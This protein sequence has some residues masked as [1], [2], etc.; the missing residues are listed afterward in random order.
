[1]WE[2][3][4]KRLVMDGESAE[5]CESDCRRTQESDAFQSEQI[6]IARSAKEAADQ[7][8]RS[9]RRA[10]II[11]VVAVIV[12]V[13]AIAIATIPLFVDQADPLSVAIRTFLD[14]I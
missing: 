13:I 11:A 12:A 10:N 3:P 4:P 7:A 5:C 1:M 6:A 9:A 2:N 8:I 14:S